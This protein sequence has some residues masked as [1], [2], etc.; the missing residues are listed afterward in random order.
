MDKAPLPDPLHPLVAF[1]RNLKA[2]EPWKD[3]WIFVLPDGTHIQIGH[4]SDEDGRNEFTVSITHPIGEVVEAY[5]LTE[6]CVKVTS[7]LTMVCL[8]DSLTDLLVSADQ[9]WYS[10]D[11]EL[12]IQDRQRR[13]KTLSAR[14]ATYATL[15]TRVVPKLEGTVV[16]AHA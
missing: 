7:N 1:C 5:V 6:D 15:L 9:A 11:V 3:D 13:A 8:A 14:M 16:C 12:E 2:V 4:T 10:L